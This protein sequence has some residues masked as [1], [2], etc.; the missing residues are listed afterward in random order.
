VLG[1]ILLPKILKAITSI[2]FVLIAIAGY[3]YNKKNKKYFS[4]LFAGLIFS[5]T[6]DVFLAVSNKGVFLILGLVSFAITHVLY[7]T[8]F[9]NLVAIELKDIGLALVIAIPTVC[10]LAIKDGFDFAGIFLPVVLYTILISIMVA[11]AFSLLKFRRG[12]LPSIVLIITGAVLFFISDFILV[13]YLFYTPRFE[14]LGYLNLILYYLGQGVLAISFR[15][16]IRTKRLY[17]VK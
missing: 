8:A 2:F 15:K 6:G 7:T 17:I 4:Y 1:F 3:K 11:K 9:C 14:I 16:S 12:N 5:L 10:V 13:F